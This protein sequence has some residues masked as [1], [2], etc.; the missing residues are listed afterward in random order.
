MAPPARCPH[1]PPLMGRPTTRL[2]TLGR[3][4]SDSSKRPYRFRASTALSVRDC[5]GPDLVDV[6]GIE[7]ESVDHLPEGCHR[8]EGVAPLEGR[9]VLGVFQYPNQALVALDQGALGFTQLDAH[10]VFH[11]LTLR[12]PG[13]PI[14]MR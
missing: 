7:V 11:A 3:R 4:G 1:H 10:H 8:F 13:V 14:T 5:S 12:S 2:T 6:S 9:E